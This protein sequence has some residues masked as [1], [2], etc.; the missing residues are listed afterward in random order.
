M[1]KALLLIAIATGLCGCNS[2]RDGNWDER[3]MMDGCRHQREGENAGV[4]YYWKCDD[5]A[6]TWGERQCHRGWDAEANSVVFWKCRTECFEE[7]R[8]VSC[9]D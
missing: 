7:G 8:Q 3:I 4:R 9:E 6:K 2:Q 5:F 1:K